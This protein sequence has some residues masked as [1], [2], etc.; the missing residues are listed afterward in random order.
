MKN[1]Y[2]D[3]DMLLH[4]PGTLLYVGNGLKYENSFVKRKLEIMYNIMY[5]FRTMSYCRM[6]VRWGLWQNTLAQ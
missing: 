1:S 6:L 5:T 3:Y 2:L 4:V